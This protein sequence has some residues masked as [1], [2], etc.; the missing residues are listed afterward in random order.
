MPV[1]KTVASFVVGLLMGVGGALAYNWQM[2]HAVR[3][4]TPVADERAGDRGPAER[5]L[6][7]GSGVRP[8]VVALGTLEPKGGIIHVASPLAGYRI[9][10]IEGEEGVS[11]QQGDLLVQLDSA[12]DQVELQLIDGQ[13]AD[14]RQR[15]Q[16]EIEQ[17]E[18]ALR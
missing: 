16:A 3:T 4:E 17:A 2:S 6:G 10:K 1:F 18:Q 15:Q 11:V 14:A 13:L 12:V 7:S 9:E 8:T 5:R